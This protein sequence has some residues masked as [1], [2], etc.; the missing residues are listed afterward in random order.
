[1][2]MSSPPTLHR[3][4]DV[5]P[6][7]ARDLATLGA[8]HMKLLD[9]GP[10]A[11][12]GERF[13]RE[14][15]YGI[16]LRDGLM[17]A[18]IYDVDGDPA[19]FIAYAT[20]SV[21]FHRSAITRHWAYLASVLILAILGDPRRIFRLAK[22]LTLILRYRPEIPAR[23][24]VGHVVAIGVLPPYLTPEFARRTGLRVAEELL[25][26]AFSHFLSVGVKTVFM[27]VDAHNKSALLFY[28]RLGARIE[29]GG[30]AC[31]PV[32]HVWFDLHR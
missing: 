16:H 8:L 7:N 2:L 32:Y 10:I 1:M 21:T 20:D 30:Q 27:A 9:F 12:L 25:A 5:D 14:I 3:F 19:G 11:G 22:A 18:A 15:C 13:A 17:R 4:R 31:R 24:D 29:A 6:T 26:H 28:H 23:P